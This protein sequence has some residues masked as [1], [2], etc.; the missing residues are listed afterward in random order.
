MFTP[1]PVQFRYSPPYTA[2]VPFLIL[3]ETGR[4]EDREI[5]RQ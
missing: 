4:F 1:S 2:M 5:D 3:I